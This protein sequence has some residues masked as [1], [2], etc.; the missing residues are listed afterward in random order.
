MDTNFKQLFDENYAHLCNYASSLIRDKYT[1]ED[2]VQTVF[3]QLWQK[4]K[5]EQLEHPEPYLLNCVKFKCIDFLRSKKNKKEV[6]L[7]ELPEAETYQEQAPSDEEIKALLNYFASKLPP[8][9]QEVF[10]MSRIRGMS[11]KEIALAL[12]ISE[13][14][15]EN[16]MGAALKRL[17]L[18]LKKHKQIVILSIIS[19]TIL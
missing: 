7:T 13:K 1:A 5:W 12:D 18:I 19:Q 11:Y 8:K 2:L 3:V 14:T 16:H 9:M 17:R 6:L 15:V 10:L 4:G